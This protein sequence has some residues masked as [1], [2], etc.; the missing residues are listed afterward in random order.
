VLGGPVLDKDDPE[1][2]GVRI[3]RSFWKVSAYKG[4]D[5]RLRTAA[6]VLSQGDLI[7]TLERLDLDPFRL[8]QVTLPELRQTTGLD[9][10][11]LAET[12]VMANP[13][14]QLSLP[15]LAGPEAAEQKPALNRE[16]TSRGDLVL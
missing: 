11:A 1:F 9:F 3:P 15:E 12:D 6:F 10:S 5:D 13:E 16:I 7:A 14:L 4:E 8:F 2:R